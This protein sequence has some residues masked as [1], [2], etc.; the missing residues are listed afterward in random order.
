MKSKVWG[1]LYRKF[2]TFQLFKYMRIHKYDKKLHK[3]EDFKK[4]K[5]E[6]VDKWKL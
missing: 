1:W 5:K 3:W 4:V 6:T 2:M